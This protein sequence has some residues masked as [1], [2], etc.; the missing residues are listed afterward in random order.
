MQVRRWQVFAVHERQ[1]GNQLP[2]Q[3]MLLQRIKETRWL[4]CCWLQWM[5]LLAWMWQQVVVVDAPTT[6][7]TPAP[8]PAA[9]PPLIAVAVVMVSE[10]LQMWMQTRC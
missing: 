10:F 5:V 9:V 8:A 6:A 7:S 1:Q 2:P 3:L 4:Q